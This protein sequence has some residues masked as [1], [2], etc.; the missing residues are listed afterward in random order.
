MQKYST[1]FE[2]SYIVF[3]EA[4]NCNE[5]KE[6][7]VALKK[8]SKKA[9]TFKQWCLVLDCSVADSKL[10]RIAMKKVLELAITFEQLQIAHKMT[11]PAGCVKQYYQFRLRWHSFAL[12]KMTKIA[13][14]F[15][16]WNIIYRLA[17]ADDNQEIQ[18]IALDNMSK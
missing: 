12:L 10:E 2:Q 3:I 1:T 7:Q 4:R 18:S 17:I 14:S 13:G 15:D 8:M 6:Q 16:Q 5:F 11:N 9:L